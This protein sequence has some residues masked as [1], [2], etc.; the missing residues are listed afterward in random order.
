MLDLIILMVVTQIIV[1]M[2]PISSTGHV[3]LLEKAALKWG[4]ISTPFEFPEWFEYCLNLPSLL[5]LGFFFRK[6]FMALVVRSITLKTRWILRHSLRFSERVWL[7]LSCKLILYVVVADLVTAIP[8]FAYKIYRVTE[9]SCLQHMLGFLLTGSALIS[10]H[11]IPQRPATSLT[12][13]R[14]LLLGL[15][16]G[17]A[18]LFSYSRFGSTF[19]T[20]CW[21]GLTP[22][23]S[24]EV[25]FLMYAPLLLASGLQGIITAPW[26]S[27]F[28][29]ELCNIWFFGALT[30][31]TIASYY[32]F[33]AVYRAAMQGTLWRL[34]FYMLIPALLMFFL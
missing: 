33:C 22:R 34:G 28:T 31:A 1:E 11:F 12:L 26:G 23:R 32:V 20:G 13:P 6:S 9:P 10:L 27:M 19:V 3:F 14:A 18:K 5:V 17:M 21:L 24:M 4:L 2:I 16:Q 25:S 29:H 7:Q 30:G 8:Y 15:V